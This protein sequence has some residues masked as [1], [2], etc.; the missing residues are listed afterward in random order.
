MARYFGEHMAMLHAAT[1]PSTSQTGG[2]NDANSRPAEPDIEREPAEQRLTRIPD[3][4]ST[5][6]SS[7]LSYRAVARNMERENRSILRDATSLRG[8]SATIQDAN[9]RFE[10][11]QR[12]TEAVLTE[13]RNARL[14]IERLRD[15]SSM[16]AEIQD[17]RDTLEAAR[18]GTRNHMRLAMERQL[19]RDSTPPARPVS[20]LICLIWTRAQPL[21]ANHTYRP[22]QNP[23][24][25]RP[26]WAEDWPRDRRPDASTGGN[27][28]QSTPRVIRSY[29]D[30]L[31]PSG[32]SRMPNVP[33]SYDMGT[34]AARRGLS[35][36]GDAT[37]QHLVPVDGLGDRN[38]SLSPEDDDVWDTL[39]SSITPDPQPPS[40]GTSFASTSAPASAAT[41]QTTTSNSAAQTSLTTPDGLYGELDAEHP[42]ESGGDNSD[43]ESEELWSGVRRLRRSYADIVGRATSRAGGRENEDLEMMGGGVDDMQRIV[44]NLAR[45][46]DIPDEWWAE[47]GLSR[48]LPREA[49]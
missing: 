6:P 42:C 29:A 40:V 47:V 2:W 10:E 16:A 1:S 31:R 15:P 7:D 14:A 46:E 28:S 35:I 23:R 30:N 19:S 4:T 38:R 3:N 48:S 45:R 8:F 49:A 32:A 24:H 9:D 18:N 37:Q 39:L 17:A 36:P 13:S 43:T 22:A 41:S 44:R 12:H 5:R 11:L 20:I 34:V 33:A 21:N 26:I 25:A 27:N